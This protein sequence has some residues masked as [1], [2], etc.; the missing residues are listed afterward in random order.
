MEASLH[1]QIN[2]QQVMKVK[3]HLDKIYLDVLVKEQ[4]S[5]LDAGSVWALQFLNYKW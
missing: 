5:E 1:M 2:W 4:P 3:R